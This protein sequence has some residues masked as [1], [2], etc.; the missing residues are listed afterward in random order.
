MTRKTPSSPDASLEAQYNNRAAVPDHPAVLARWKAEAEA[1]RAAHPPLAL[2]YG[3]GEREVIDLFEAAPAA[4]QDHA[5][6]VVFI[7]GG[8]WQALDPSWFSWIAPAFLSQGISVA[9]PGY[10]L[11][12]HVRLGRIVAQMREVT[13]LLRARTGV[14]PIVTGHSAGGHLSACMLSEGKASAALAI[15]GVFDLRPLV[16]T[17]LNDALRLDTNG[18]AALSPLFWPPPNGGAPGG[19]E[20]DCFVGGAETAEFIRQSRD[21][22]EHWGAKGADTR[23]EALD[24]LNHFTVLDPLADPDSGLVKRIVELARA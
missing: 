23:F 22:A 4:D 1:A 9:V 17:S 13:T 6:V 19:T 12:P 20:L 3:P 15:S 16:Q 10:D 8:Y 24:G 18:A 21:M 5:P 11:C 14:R 7:H 2:R